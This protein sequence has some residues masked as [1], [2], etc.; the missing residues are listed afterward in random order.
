MLH[1]RLHGM[2]DRISR[3]LRAQNTAQ[4]RN[5]YALDRPRLAGHGQGDE[6]AL[7]TPP[8]INVS[9]AQRRHIIRVD[10][11]S[12]AS[13]AVSE[14]AHLEHPVIRELVLHVHV[15]LLG[16]AVRGISLLRSQRHGLGTLKRE[17]VKWDAVPE[18]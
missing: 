14:I 2:E 12:Q 18:Q 16:I 13:S 1:L 5:G 3:V 10:Q 9:G 15:P 7:V 6:Y 11:V 4:R 17:L 8:L